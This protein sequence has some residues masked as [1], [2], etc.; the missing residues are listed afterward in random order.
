M[1]KLECVAAAG[2]KHA[3]IR[4]Q[5]INRAAADRAVELIDALQGCEIRFEGVDS[6]SQGREIRRRSFD[7][8]LVRHNDEVE[9]LAG[10]AF[11]EFV[12]DACGSAGDDG[13]GTRG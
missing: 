13:E 11:S 9:A 10:A 4:D 1:P 6:G 3:R 12:A 8:R 2:R 7:F 5:G